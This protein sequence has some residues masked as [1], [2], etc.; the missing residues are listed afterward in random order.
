MHPHLMTH[1]EAVAQHDGRPVATGVQVV[2]GLAVH[3]G[4]GH[5]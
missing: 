4:E 1:A 2:D 5:G 3:V